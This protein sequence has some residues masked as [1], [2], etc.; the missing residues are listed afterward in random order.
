[1]LGKLWHLG[2]GFILIGCLIHFFCHKR[3]KSALHK[4]MN[5]LAVILTLASIIT[6]VVYLS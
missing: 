6:V 2:L 5:Q 4:R 1:M 3:Q